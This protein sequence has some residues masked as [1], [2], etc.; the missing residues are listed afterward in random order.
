MRIEWLKR[1]AKGRLLIFFH[2]WGMDARAVQ[3]LHGEC[4]IAVVCDYRNLTVDVKLLEELKQYR[5]IDVVA[6]SM[7]VWAAANVLPLCE[8]H[9]VRLVALN[10]TERPVDNSY[11]IPERIYRL[12]ER[13]MNAEGRDKFMS[14]MFVNDE[15]RRRFQACRPQRDLQEVCDE[16][17][18]IREQSAGLQHTLDWNRVYVSS[19]D[20]IFV[21][22][23]QMAW[24]QNRVK[25]IVP[26][27]GGHY[28]F[29]H[30]ES[31]EQILEL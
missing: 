18:L 20:V 19:G 7:G 13:G 11:G 5:H 2:G 6:W 23:Q 3:H 21:P 22:A 27:E 10:G 14:R 24:W 29:Y 8:I 26:L 30:F 16:L 31:W 15:E 1:E 4:D 12:T 28:P 17:I 25:E 9:P